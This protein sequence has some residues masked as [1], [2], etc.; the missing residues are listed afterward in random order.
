M[1]N[2]MLVLPTP[3][4]DIKAW[5]FEDSSCVSIND[6]VVREGLE[7]GEASNLAWD[8]FGAIMGKV[9]MVNEVHKRDAEYANHVCA[10]DAFDGAEDEYEGYI[11]PDMD[12]PLTHE[13]NEGLV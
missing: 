2:P 7:S 4:G 6:Y 8:M 5:R 1:I 9:A 3:A 11:Y 12:H 13:E 10:R